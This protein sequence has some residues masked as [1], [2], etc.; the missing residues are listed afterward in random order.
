M[1][2]FVLVVAIISIVLWLLFVK[3]IIATPPETTLI[4]LGALGLLYL[5]LTSTT[6]LI[7][8]IT[9]LV[10]SKNT[11]KEDTSSKSKKDTKEKNST[12]FDAKKA[13]V[14][15]LKRGSIISFIL[16]TALSIRAFTNN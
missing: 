11:R 14:K 6:S 1:S 5:S 15:A 16:V 10:K 2:K 9:K 4:K 8:Y 12:P 7:L 3:L 13:Y